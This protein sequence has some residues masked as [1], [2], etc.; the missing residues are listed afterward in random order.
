VH[1]ITSTAGIVAIAAGAVALL[2]LLL[3]LI[4]MLRLRRVR[5]EQRV[6]L[7][8][9]SQ[10]LVA[11]AAALRQQF[12][13]LYGYVQDMAGGLTSRMEAAEHRLDQA[14]A[15][16]ALVRYDAYGEMSGRQSTSIA[17]LD[18]NRSGLILSSIHHRDQARLYAKEVREG[19][20]E[21]EL[22]PEEDEAIR[23]ALEADSR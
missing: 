12:E 4:L 1:N 6:I 21:L 18:A 20:P 22:S 3:C 2:A 17:L 15:Y 9:G 16:S 5:A 19:R 8:D 10:D 13:V 23:R 7:G 14:I 11:H